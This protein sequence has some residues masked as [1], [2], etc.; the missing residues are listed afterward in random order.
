M[1]N[2]RTTLMV[3]KSQRQ[4]AELLVFDGALLLLNMS[5]FS[6]CW[7]LFYEHHLYLSFE[8]YGD[9]M[10]IGLFLALNMVFAHLY[11]GFELLTSRITELIYSHFIALVMTH[12]FMYMVNIFFHYGYPIK[13]VMYCM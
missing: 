7:F 12:F 5:I 3:N 11:G 10:V 13:I 6:V 9:Y 2:G 4:N 1:K 8:G